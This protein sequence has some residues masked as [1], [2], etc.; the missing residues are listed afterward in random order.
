MKKL[1]VRVG[2]YQGQDG[3]T[4]GR[5]VNIGVLMQKDGKEYILLD[6]TISIAG[7]AQQQNVQAMKNNEQ[8]RDRVMVGLFEEDNQQQSAPQQNYNQAPQQQYGQQPPPQGQ[9]YR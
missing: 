8:F 1:S 3:S 2:E 7:L 5:Y 9:Q 4:K 6:P